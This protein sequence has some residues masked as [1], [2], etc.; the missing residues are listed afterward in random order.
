MKYNIFIIHTAY[1]IITF[2][3][4]HSFLER[5]GM[6][7]QFFDAKQHMQISLSVRPS[8]RPSDMIS[9]SLGSLEH[10][11]KRQKTI[12]RRKKLQTKLVS[13]TSYDFDLIPCVCVCA[14]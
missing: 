10:L 2:R 8:I 14:R 4:S 6:K 13:Q 9:I 11:L 3:L 7:S 12:I 5:F 1:F